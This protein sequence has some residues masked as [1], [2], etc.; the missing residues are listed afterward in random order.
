MH[1]HAVYAFFIDPTN[2]ERL[3]DRGWFPFIQFSAGEFHQLR[4]GIDD[5]SELD[6]VE[7]NI[8]SEAEGIVRLHFHSDMGRKP[9]TRELME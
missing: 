3:I 9:T 6:T 1:F 5:S 2:P 4:Y 7:A 8:V